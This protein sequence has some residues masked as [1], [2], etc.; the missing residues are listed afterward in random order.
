LLQGR[1][2]EFHDLRPFFRFLYATGCRVGAAEK[3]T[4]K[5]VRKNDNDEFV[6]DLPAKIM[7]TNKGLS[8][9]ITGALLQPVA[10]YLSS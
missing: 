1:V 5:M 9:T 6:I 7:K 3:I 2:R 10:E 4:W 8:L